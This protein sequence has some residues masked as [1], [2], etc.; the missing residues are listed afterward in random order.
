[1][2]L[3]VPVISLLRSVLVHI[4]RIWCQETLIG[5]Y[6]IQMEF[7]FY[8]KQYYAIGYAEHKSVPKLMHVFNL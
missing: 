8:A 6:N 2:Q 7:P 4:V 3:P 5:Y 1:M